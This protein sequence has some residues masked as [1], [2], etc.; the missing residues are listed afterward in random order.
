M[1]R[2]TFCRIGESSVTDLFV[3]GRDKLTVSGLA[4]PLADRAAEQE[5][6]DV[7]AASGAGCFDRGTDVS[8]HTTVAAAGFFGNR[9]V[10]TVGAAEL[11]FVT[12][13]KQ[14]SRF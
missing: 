5:C 12:E 14:K 11:G 9:F 10:Q 6:G 3:K 2:G 7:A 4:C 1:I 13:Q 8:F